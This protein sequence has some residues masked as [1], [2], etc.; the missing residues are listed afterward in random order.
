MHHR[1]MV[2]SQRESK[3]EIARFGGLKPPSP[4][5]SNASADEKQ[6]PDQRLGDLFTDDSGML[7]GQGK[8][9]RSPRRYRKVAPPCERYGSSPVGGIA[10]GGLFDRKQRSNVGATLPASL[11]DE[12]WLQVRQPNFIRPATRVDFHM[13]GAAIVSAVDQQPATAGQSHFAEG[14]LLGALHRDITPQ[15][16]GR[17]QAARDWGMTQ[18]T[19]PARGL[20]RAAAANLVGGFL[21]TALGAGAGS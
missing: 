16:G 12:F 3:N 10:R 4:A 21:P 5:I 17:R 8:R 19:P 9:F 2:R 18:K 11:T 13:M 6:N 20:G 1:I 14:D 15:R 7:R